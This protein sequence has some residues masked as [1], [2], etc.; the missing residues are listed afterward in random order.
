MPYGHLL[1][2]VH[3]AT[4]NP[5]SAYLALH[6]PEMKYGKPLKKRH[7]KN[8]MFKETTHIVTA[9][10]ICMSGHIPDVVVGFHGNPFWWFPIAVSRPVAKGCRSPT[11]G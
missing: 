11:P 2:K 6:D 3:P 8:V 9:T 4:I 7:L 1:Y 5:C 10:W